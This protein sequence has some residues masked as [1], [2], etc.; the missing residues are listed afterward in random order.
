MTYHEAATCDMSGLS[1]GYAYWL[2]GNGYIGGLDNP[3]NETKQN[4]ID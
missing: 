2:A 1:I 4:N 3:V